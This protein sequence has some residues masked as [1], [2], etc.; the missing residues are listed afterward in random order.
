MPADIV[1]VCDYCMVFIMVF[2]VIRTNGCEH[3]LCVILYCLRYGVWCYQNQR[4]PADMVFLRT[5][6]HD[7]GCFIRT[8]Q[9]DGETDW[10]LRLAVQATQRLPSN[11]VSKAL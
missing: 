6:E 2:G 11:V 3:T 5:T 7:G 4:V 1:R 8:D 9:M 10:K